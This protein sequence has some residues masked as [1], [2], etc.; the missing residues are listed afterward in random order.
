MNEKAKQVLTLVAT[1]VGVLAPFLGSFTPG[2]SS[3][4]N[5]SS[6]YFGDVLIIPAD[7]AFVIWAP[8]Y[9]GFLAFAVYQALPAQR[10][11]PRFMRTRLWLGASALLNAAWILLFDNLLFV[12]S[13]AVITAMLVT[14]LRMHRT[15][16][17][18]RTRVYGLERYL[19]IPFSLYA[20]WLTVATIVN[21]AGT[22]EV[23]GWG[24]FGLSYPVW[25]VIMLL[26]ATVVGLATRLYW[27]DPVYGGV[28]VWAFVGVAVGVG[29]PQTVS[30]T[31]WLLAAVLLA[32]LLPPV[33][34]R[35]APA[36]VAR[37]AH[38]AS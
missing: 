30:L 16:E 7:Y 25:A 33:A 35:L 19:R 11:N 21:A 15:L 31:A 6:Q 38:G 5:I 13:L 37:N 29:Q 14:A 32:T 22:L 20:G 23:T 18:G 4:G 9:L 26:I 36:R 24:A 27:S 28:F 1:F 17:I 2:D 34:R 12:L 3:T 10:H 8:I